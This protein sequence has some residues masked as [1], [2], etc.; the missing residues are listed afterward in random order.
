[1]LNSMSGL[2]ISANICRQTL[3]PK[4]IYRSCLDRS[5]RELMRNRRRLKLS[6]MKELRV[7]TSEQLLRVAFAFDP[8]QTAILLLGGDEA[9]KNQ[10]RFYKKFIAK[11]DEVYDA[12]L[13]SLKKNEN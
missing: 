3:L 2:P 1:M 4:S 7:S 8:T 6:N 12:H 11:A 10:Q 5:S 13:A 9:G